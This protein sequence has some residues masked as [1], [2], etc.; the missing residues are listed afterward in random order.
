MTGNVYFNY[1]HFN[2][3]AYLNDSWMSPTI[4]LTLGTK[5]LP[6]DSIEPSYVVARI[7]MTVGSSLTLSSFKLQGIEQ[8]KNNITWSIPSV[9]PAT[10]SNCFPIGT[11][12]STD[13][14]LVSIENLIPGVHT[15]QGK[16]IVSVNIDQLTFTGNTLICT[17]N[18]SYAL[19]NK[20]LVWL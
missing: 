12:V 7:S 10:S 9:V 15:L 6:I 20:Y 17:D 4:L 13:R 14:G 19:Q 1:V 3:S 5:T 18:P 2:D 16:S 8:L 11:M